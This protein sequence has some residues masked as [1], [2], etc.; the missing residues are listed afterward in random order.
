[1]RRGSRIV[2]VGIAVL[3]AVALLGSCGGGGSN[4]AARKLHAVILS[5]CGNGENIEE[6]LRGLVAGVKATEREFEAAAVEENKSQVLQAMKENLAAIH[7][8]LLPFNDCIRNVLREREGKAP[9]GPVYAPPRP[10]GG[11][12]TVRRTGPAE[13][14]PGGPPTSSLPCSYVDGDGKVRIEIFGDGG[15]CVKMRPSS[16]LSFSYYRGAGPAPIRVA[17]GGYEMWLK[18]GQEGVIPGPVGNYLANGSHGAQVA[19]TAGAGTLIV[20]PEPSGR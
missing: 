3:A 20:E 5:G 13:I 12:V 10:S 1:M 7:R 4:A 14:E 15:G 19:G 8:E 18:P 2:L 9:L 16:Q 11:A 6:E 17:I